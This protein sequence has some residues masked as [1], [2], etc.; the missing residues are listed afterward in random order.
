MKPKQIL[1]ALSLIFFS[2]FTQ[3]YATPSDATDHTAIEES[4][5]AH[6]VDESHGGHDSHDDHSPHPLAVLPFVLL[7][8]MIATGPLFYEHFWHKRY[9]LVAIVLGTIVVVYYVFALKEYACPHSC[10]V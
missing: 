10:L 5:G 7:L 4:H 2:G 3:G 8:G 9:P 1:L 6:A